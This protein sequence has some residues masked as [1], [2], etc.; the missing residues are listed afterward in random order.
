MTRTLRFIGVVI[1]KVERNYTPPDPPSTESR[2]TSAGI[3]VWVF[4]LALIT[5]IALTMAT[6]FGSYCTK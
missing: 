5:A 2:S 6:L 3:G 4:T 1:A